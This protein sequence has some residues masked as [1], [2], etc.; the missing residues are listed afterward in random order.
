MVDNHQLLKIVD[1]S[2][3]LVAV[4]GPEKHQ[5]YIGFDTLKTEISRLVTAVFIMT[6]IA[7]KCAQMAVSLPPLT[8][9]EVAY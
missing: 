2:E 3:P 7:F 6:R 4:L 5:A 1:I 9:V 8:S